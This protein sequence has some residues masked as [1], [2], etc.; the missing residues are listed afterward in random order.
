[1]DVT[2]IIFGHD[3][4]WDNRDYPFE[5]P[6]PLLDIRG[7]TVANRQIE[8]F[9]KTGIKNIIYLI[10]PDSTKLYEDELLKK[11]PNTNFNFVE[12]ES[13]LKT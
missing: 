3:R 1:V 11:Y 12:I 10:E 7:K 6:K 2:V 4:K 5:L 13:D 8:A 9:V